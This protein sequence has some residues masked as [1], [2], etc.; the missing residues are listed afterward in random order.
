MN[1]DLTFGDTKTMVAVL[2]DDL[3]ENRDRLANFARLEQ[4]YTRST[5]YLEDQLR[6][7]RQRVSALE[8]EFQLLEGYRQQQQRS[9]N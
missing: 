5:I 2:Q 7:E 3:S 6:G 9:R 8:A 4:E 1:F